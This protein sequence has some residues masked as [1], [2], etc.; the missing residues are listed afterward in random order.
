MYMTYCI[1]QCLN[2]TSFNDMQRCTYNRKTGRAVM[3][4][5]CSDCPVYA[6][7]DKEGQRVRLLYGLIE[8]NYKKICGLSIAYKFSPP[9]EYRTAAYICG[10]TDTKLKAWSP[11]SA[12]EI[13]CVIEGLPKEHVASGR[14]RIQAFKGGCSQKF[15]ICDSDEN[16][17]FNTTL[18]P[19]IPMQPAKNNTCLVVTFSLDDKKASNLQFR[20]EYCHEPAPFICLTNDD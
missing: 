15:Q 12:Q 3:K 16:P 7:N 1:A 6:L 11:K 19:F 8:K 13:Q 2:I 5:K 4:P 9:V 18:F 17:P 10:I 20:E 14:L